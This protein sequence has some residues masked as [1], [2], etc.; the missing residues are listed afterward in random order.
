MIAAKA[1]LLF[2]LIVL[3]QEHPPLPLLWVQ[4]GDRID[5]LKRELTG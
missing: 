4:Y 5:M 3:D 2:P 1:Y